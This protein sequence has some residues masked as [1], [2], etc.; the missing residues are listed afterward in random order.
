MGLLRKNT[1]NEGEGLEK[2]RGLRTKLKGTSV[3]KD[4]WKHKRQKRELRW[5]SQKE[6]KNE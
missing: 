6:E 3:F 4:D 5:N 2:I 1:W